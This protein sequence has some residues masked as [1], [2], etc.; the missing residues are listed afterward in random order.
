[1]ISYP[2]EIS[3]FTTYYII[4]FRAQNSGRDR[5]GGRQTRAYTHP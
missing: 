5:V 3:W 4:S 2:H 1:M